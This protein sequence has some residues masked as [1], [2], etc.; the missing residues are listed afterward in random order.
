MKNKDYNI[1]RGSIFLNIQFTRLGNRVNIIIYILL[2]LQDK[3]CQFY[4]F[5]LFFKTILFSFL[6]S[7]IK[8]I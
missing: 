3:Q 1:L 2:P 6:D 5:S 8:T 4:L 7:W